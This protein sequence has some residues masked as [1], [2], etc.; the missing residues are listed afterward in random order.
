MENKVLTKENDENVIVS[1]LYDQLSIEQLINLIIDSSNSD[2]ILAQARQELVNRGKDNIQLRILIKKQCK[3]NIESLE[4]L[5]KKIDKESNRNKDII[6][7]FK[8][9][10]LSS[11]SVLDRLQLEWQKHDLSL[12]A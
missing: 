5:L 3:S 7:S 1:F 2:F 10:F 4:A 8:Q 11:I 6:K 9:K 12:R